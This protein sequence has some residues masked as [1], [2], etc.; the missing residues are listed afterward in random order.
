ML[1]F[2]TLALSAAASALA[3]PHKIRADCSPK[4]TAKAH[5]TSTDGAFEGWLDFTGYLD[6][7]P[8]DVKFSGLK[9][10]KKD[11]FGAFAY[12]IH[13]NPVP[14][15]GNCSKTLAHLDPLKATQGFIC[16]PAFPQY[17]ET[18]D[19]SGKHGKLNATDDGN[20]P[21]ITYSDAY[22]RFFPQDLSL[23]G[24]SVVIHSVN[25]TRIACGNIIS[26]WDGT[27]DASWNPTYQPSTYVTDYPTTAPVQPT[28]V[29]IPSNGTTWPDEATIASFPHPLP[30]PALS[31]GEALNVKLGSITHTVK[32]ANAEHEITQPKEEKVDGN[33]PFDGE[34]GC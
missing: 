24:R 30:V 17:C 8:T 16:N 32:Y 4:L 19:L 2:T 6:G 12:H 23:L 9:G 29:V 18:G 22:V 13:T 34:W 10:F 31:L 14:S 15:D 7:R 27:A 20:L 28:P 21:D 25:A 11:I 33:G 3:A 5:V 1:F 26:R